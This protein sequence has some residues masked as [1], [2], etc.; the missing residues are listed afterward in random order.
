M[1]KYKEEVFP[2]SIPFSIIIIR[3]Q[4]LGSSLF[5]FYLANGFLT[6]IQWIDIRVQ[7]SRARQTEHNDNYS[8]IPKSIQSV[9]LFDYSFA[10]IFRVCA[11]EVEI[12][13]NRLDLSEALP[14]TELLN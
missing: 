6:L 10:R 3:L 5:L 2:R 9:L 13:R 14:R 1:I 7:V 12:H 4:G 11:I 8:I